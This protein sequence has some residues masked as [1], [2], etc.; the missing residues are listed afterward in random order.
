M[1]KLLK[2]PVLLTERGFGKTKME[3]LTLA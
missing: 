1:Q 3:N 2:T